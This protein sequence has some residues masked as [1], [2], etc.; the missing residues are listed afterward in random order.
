MRLPSE[1]VAHERI[2][3][4]GKVLITQIPNSRLME[5]SAPPFKVR[6]KRKSGLTALKCPFNLLLADLVFTL[7]GFSY[8]QH[9]SIRCVI[10]P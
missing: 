1:V 5:I 3:Q 9:N 10:I 4:L 2:L 7:I 8:L 6:R